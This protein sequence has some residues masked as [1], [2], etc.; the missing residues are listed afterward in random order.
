MGKHV[1]RMGEVINAYKE[2]IKGKKVKLS[3]CLTKH[4]AMKTYW[5]NGGIAP[6]IP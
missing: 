2:V 6:R 4:L 1:E 3:L 5:R